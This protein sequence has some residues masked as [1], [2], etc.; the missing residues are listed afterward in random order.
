LYRPAE[1]GKTKLMDEA[2][3]VLK[4]M[5]ASADQMM[6][7]ATGSME[8]IKISNAGGSMEHKAMHGGSMEKLKLTKA[9][10]SSEEMGKVAKVSSEELLVKKA[11]SLLILLEFSNSVDF[12]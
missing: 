7:K 8:Q 9:A 11:S 4:K 6:A 2:M 10:D 12:V 1:P 5:G 3:S